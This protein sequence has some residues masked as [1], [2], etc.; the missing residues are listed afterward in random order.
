MGGRRGSKVQLIISTEVLVQ[1]HEVKI[2]VTHIKVTIITEVV[3]KIHE[4]QIEIIQI[5]VLVEGTAGGVEDAGKEEDE[6]QEEEDLS[7]KCLARVVNSTA[8]VVSIT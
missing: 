3:A 4:V 6:E 8:E 5:Q 2:E 1:I 7:T